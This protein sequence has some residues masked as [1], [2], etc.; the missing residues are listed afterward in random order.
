MISKKYTCATYGLTRRTHDSGT[1]LS[2]LV[3]MPC[4]INYMRVKVLRFA[5]A[6]HRHPLDNESDGERN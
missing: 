6:S 2:Q 3:T 1:I 4:S 5:S